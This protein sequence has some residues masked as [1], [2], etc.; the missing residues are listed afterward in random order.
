VVDGD[1]AGARALEAA[2]TGGRRA[3]LLAYHT[4]PGS[5]PDVAVLPAE[6][7]GYAKGLYAALHDLD[8]RD[9]NV[10]YVVRPPADAAWEG[11]HDRLRRAAHR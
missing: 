9:Y 7:A 8:A 10:V 2:R 3:A 1:E 11:I 4:P 5:D 6:P